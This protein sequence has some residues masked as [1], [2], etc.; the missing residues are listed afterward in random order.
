MRIAYI[1][2]TIFVYLFIEQMY[3][4]TPFPQQ[5][6]KLGVVKYPLN[7][8]SLQAKTPEDWAVRDKDSFNKHCDKQAI[9][10]YR[11]YK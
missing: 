9:F 6:Y 8:F 7:T 4:A 2:K 10:V 3:L 11:S 1:T 5:R